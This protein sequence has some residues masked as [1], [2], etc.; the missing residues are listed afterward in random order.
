MKS[1]NKFGYTKMEVLVVVVLLGIVAFITI[2]S[3][4]YA[5]AIDTTDSV[6]E[7]KALI[8]KQ[9]EEY[10]LD[11]LD[12]FNEAD[13]NYILVSELVE[14]GYMMANDDGI[15]TSPDNSGKTFNDN[16]IK[17]EYNKDNNKVEATFID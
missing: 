9:A 13:T 15:V 11:N 2:N 17:L 7:V 10:A 12:L 16:K 14:N 4:S 3:T 8:E 5:F 1:L 6:K